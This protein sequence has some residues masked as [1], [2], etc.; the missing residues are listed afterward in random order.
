MQY[1]A[2]LSIYWTDLLD[3]ISALVIYNN[4]K[5]D[6]FFH[7]C[8][9]AFFFLLKQKQAAFIYRGLFSAAD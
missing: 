1:L 3:I 4:L 7:S 5:K 9:C 2:A 6:M 8:A